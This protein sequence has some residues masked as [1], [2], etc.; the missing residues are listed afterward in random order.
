MREHSM[1]RSVRTAL[2]FTAGFALTFG[3]LTT[4]AQHGAGDEDPLDIR[5]WLIDR[6][7]AAYTV[8]D[9]ETLRMMRFAALAIESPE[10]DRI[11]PRGQSDDDP[12]GAA[13]ASKTRGKAKGCLPDDVVGPPAPGQKRCGEAKRDALEAQRRLRNAAVAYYRTH[14]RSGLRPDPRVYNY[15]VAEITAMYQACV[16]EPGPSNKNRTQGLAGCT[17]ATVEAQRC[18]KQTGYCPRCKPPP[19]DP[20]PPD[21]RLQ[22]PA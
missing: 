3:A 13:S 5:R 8:G 19:T 4:F 18:M 17:G 10:V 15:C 7:E 11:H 12:M 20:G 2:I 9:I 16:L 6:V 14:F 1:K 22:P 21:R